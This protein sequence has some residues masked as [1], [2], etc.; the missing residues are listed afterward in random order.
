MVA[1]EQEDATMKKTLLII[2]GSALATGF[3]IKAAPALSQTVPA[4]SNVQVVRTVDLDLSTQAGQRRLE[5]R[6]V[7]A[8]H[9]V[10]GGA[11]ATDLKA[12]NSE[13]DC[14]SEVLARGRAAAGAILAGDRADSIVLAAAE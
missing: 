3:V 4:D 2:A 1:L 14:R 6:L 10:C 8:A 13:D 7:T 9:A 5:Q 12:R 11:S